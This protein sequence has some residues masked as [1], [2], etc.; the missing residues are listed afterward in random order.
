MKSEILL[1]AIGEIREAFIREA[2]ADSRRTRFWLKTA[3]PAAAVLIL[4]FFAAKA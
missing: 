2:A 4:C 1:D 3:I